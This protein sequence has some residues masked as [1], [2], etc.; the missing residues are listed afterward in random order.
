MTANIPQEAELRHWLVCLNGLEAGSLD[1]LKCYVAG[2]IC[3]RDALWQF[4]CQGPSAI[5]EIPPD[6]WQPFD[7]GSPEVAAALAPINRGTCS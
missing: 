6:L 7:D 4:L 5:G 2:N 3:G 1:A